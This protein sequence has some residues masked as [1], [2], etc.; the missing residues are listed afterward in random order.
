MGP[1]EGLAIKMK[2]R[3]SLVLF[4]ALVAASTL[5]VAALSAAG[6]DSKTNNNSAQGAE[7]LRAKLLEVQVKESELQARARLRLR[8]RP[9]ERQ[10]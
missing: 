6:Q 9:L 1:L 2:I 3:L 7:D 4:I 10:Q 8:L 5:S